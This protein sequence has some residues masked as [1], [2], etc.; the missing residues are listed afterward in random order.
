M[1]IEA[2]SLYI[3]QKPTNFSKL[4][5]SFKSLVKNLQTI[6]LSQTDPKYYEQNGHIPELYSEL[7]QTS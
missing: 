3:I 7:F 1:K 2:E 5:Y 6:S 4:W